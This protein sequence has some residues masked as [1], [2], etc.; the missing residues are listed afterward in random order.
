MRRGKN[1]HLQRIRPRTHADH[2]NAYETAAH[3][4]LLLV[5][6]ASLPSHAHRARKMHGRVARLRRRW[7]VDSVSD[8]ASACAPTRSTG[9]SDIPLYVVPQFSYYGKRFF[10]DNLNR[11]SR[12]TKVMPH[13]QSGGRARLRSSVPSA[14]AIHRTFWSSGPR[15]TRRRH[16]WYRWRQPTLDDEQTA[17]E[18]SQP[19]SPHHLSC[20]YPSGCFPTASSPG[21]SALCMK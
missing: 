10:L 1:G 9:R 6:A 19:P 15:D 11:A 21:N 2:A 16:G 12:C 8:S 20:G 3:S 7:R 14:A 13:P 4:A 17:R 18:A 5:I